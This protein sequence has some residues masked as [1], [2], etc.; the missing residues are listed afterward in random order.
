MEPAV[1]SLG[2]ADRLFA[3]CRA[4]NRKERA[5][6]HQKSNCHHRGAGTVSLK[7][8]QFAYDPLHT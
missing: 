1:S 2:R 6:R 3:V 7:K 5:G 4:K 8:L